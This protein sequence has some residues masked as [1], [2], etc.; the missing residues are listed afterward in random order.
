MAAGG[1]ASTLIQSMAS[2]QER[3]AGA[4]QAEWLAFGS[5]IGLASGAARE[6]AAIA[7]GLSIDAARMREN[8]AHTPDVAAQRPDAA[9]W[10]E[11]AIARIEAAAK[12]MD[13]AVTGVLQHPEKAS[14]F[15]PCFVPGTIDDNRV[16][17]TDAKRLN[18]ALQLFGAHQK[19]RLCTRGE[20]LP[21]RAHG[22][23]DVCSRVV[24]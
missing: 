16:G 23:R 6:L 14:L 1:H 10:V 12:N 19:T 18:A 13:V 22:A 2:A 4:W 9:R 3:P 24:S 8:M 7:T 15:A 17:R 11:P 5:L 21:G 20:L